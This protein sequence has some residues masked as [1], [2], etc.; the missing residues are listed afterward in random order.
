MVAANHAP[1][2]ARQ[3]ADF[4][5]HVERA[6]YYR[7]YLT[8][9]IFHSTATLHST[10]AFAV[11]AA[12][13]QYIGLGFGSYI[14]PFRHPIIAAKELA[15]LDGLCA[16]R[17]VPGLAVGSSRAEFEAF[18]MA[19][20]T[21]GKRF[22]EALTAIKRLWLEDEVS[23]HGEF[24]QFDNVSLTPKPLQAPHPP[25]SIGSWTG[26]KPA[27]R[28]I[29]KHAAGWQASGLHASLE[30]TAQGWHRLEDMCVEMGR[31]P[32][33]I[34]RSMVNLIVRI[35][36]DRDAALAGVIPSHRM[37]DELIVAG[38]ESEIVDRLLAIFSTGIEEVSLFMPL[39]AFDQ[40]DAIAERVMPHL[41]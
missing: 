34:T 37:H 36:A 20:N 2:S 24:Y 14:V 40:V 19:F 11:A 10:S 41:A 30:K 1:A 8:D 32:A 31:D 6:G 9:H 39:D 35:G 26:S 23:F 16:G 29:V 13:T 22:D 18:G 4:C 38:S 28:R 17:L 12:S 3:I 15:F 5:T 21:R 25:I 7:L 33:T 27:A